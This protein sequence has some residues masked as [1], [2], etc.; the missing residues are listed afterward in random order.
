MFELDNLFSF[1][2]NH[3]NDNDNATVSSLENGKLPS[4]NNDNVENGEGNISCSFVGNALFSDFLKTNICTLTTLDD[5]TDGLFLRSTLSSTSNNNA[6]QSINEKDHIEQVDL[7]EEYAINT[8][9]LS[10][11]SFDISF[12]PEEEHLQRS[13]R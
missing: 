6:N 5:R 7:F 3:G 12:D 4:M 8:E 2:Q 10:L 1:K 11:I 13:T 9:M